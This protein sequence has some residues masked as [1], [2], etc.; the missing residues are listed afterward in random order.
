M[1][2]FTVLSL[3]VWDS[4]AEEKNHKGIENRDLIPGGAQECPSLRFQADSKS[5]SALAKQIPMLVIKLSLK[6]TAGHHLV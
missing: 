3:T 1:V 6:L 2:H 4:T 5:L